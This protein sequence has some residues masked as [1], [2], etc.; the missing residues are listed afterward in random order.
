MLPLK[1]IIGDSTRAGFLG[2]EGTGSVLPLIHKDGVR[3]L[4]SHIRVRYSR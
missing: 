1:A 2:S 4:P 3:D